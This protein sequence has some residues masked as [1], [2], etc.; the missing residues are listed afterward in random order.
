[1]PSGHHNAQRTQGT[2]TGYPR[3][4]LAKKNAVG[5][6]HAQGVPRR[7]HS[8]HSTGSR[9]LT[10]VV[11]PAGPQARARYGMRRTERHACGGEWDGP[12]LHKRKPTLVVDVHVNDVS[13][14]R[15]GR[16]AQ[17]LGD[18][19]IEELRDGLRAAG[20]RESNT[21]T[22]KLH[23]AQPHKKNDPYTQR[24]HGH[25]RTGTS[26]AWEGREGNGSV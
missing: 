7:Q 20:E 9:G 14:P 8:A 4:T 1:M 10:R 24:G 19:V 5:A 3:D 23:H 16:L 6:A 15:R 12:E 18:R 17:T 2:R 26:A 13:P 25:Q 22:P 11:M 21:A